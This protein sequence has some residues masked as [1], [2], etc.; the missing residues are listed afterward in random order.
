ME[1]NISDTAK[2]V[3]RE[4]SPSLSPDQIPAFEKSHEYPVN[5]FTT[6]VRPSDQGLAQN[7]ESLSIR[8]GLT[9]TNEESE[10]GIESTQIQGL[11]ENLR[12]DEEPAQNADEDE[13]ADGE[14]R[15][16]SDDTDEES[17]NDDSGNYAT[18]TERHPEENQPQVLEGKLET[19]R[20]VT[21]NA[22]EFVARLHAIEDRKRASQ[23]NRKRATDET[24]HA[25][26]PQKQR[27]FNT[28][29]PSWQQHQGE[30]PRMG[31]IKA[32]TYADQFAQIKANM[33]EGHDTRRLSSQAKDLK[34]ATQ[35]FGYKKVVAE[36]G[37]WKLKGMKT[38]LY[39][40]QMPLVAWMAKREL[41]KFA[42]FGGLVA[43][44]M[45]MG[46]TLVS[47]FLIEGNPP[48]KEDLQDHCR[49]TLVVVPNGT[50][51]KQWHA[52]T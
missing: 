39:N 4:D 24:N 29:V 17:D 31:A 11:K 12:Q 27:K 33:P 41:G 19:R 50:M 5:S 38:G 51:A 15:E 48:P 37:K 47:L 52:E 26:K 3:K 36:D 13:K 10:Q 9:R 20:R 1:H 8:D 43:D 34:E 45:G 22:R 35:L 28:E 32:K 23:S 40:Y 14:H 18:S 49:A 21:K 16:L 6:D 44:E 7:E 2:Q 30:A 42:P 25:Q 46:K